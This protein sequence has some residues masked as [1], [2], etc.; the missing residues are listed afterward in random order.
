MKS[1]LLRK[2]P[3]FLIITLL[4]LSGCDA[5][6][7]TKN[8]EQA[9]ADIGP[10]IAADTGSVEA[11]STETSEDG[12]D[13]SNTEK[14]SSE[15]KSDTTFMSLSAE[16]D[17]VSFVD[18]PR[19][20]G[21]WYEIATT[22][23]FQQAACFGTQAEYSFNEEQ[24]WVDVTNRCYVGSASGNLQVLEGRAELEDLETQAKL[25]VI[26]FGQGSPYWVVALDGSEGDEPYAWSV[27]SVPGGKTM[28]I[29]SRTPSIT[30]QLRKDIEDHLKERGFPVDTLIDTPHED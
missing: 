8:T 16:E 12:A 10:D 20:M 9:S 2:L 24:G 4:M 29:L 5:T 1:M 22:P 23:S 26:F 21:R 3:G 6:S 25:S 13:S 15:I 17:V 11:D 7:S 27:V 14:D 18:V 19:Y 28:W 30:E